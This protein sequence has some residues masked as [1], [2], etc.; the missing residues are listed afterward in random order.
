MMKKLLIAFLFS[1]PLLAGAGTCRVVSKTC[2]DSAE[3]KTVSGMPVFFATVGI[4]DG[5]WE[6]KNEYDCVDTSVAVNYCAGIEQTAGCGTTSSV[7][8]TTNVID[9]SCDIYTKTFR[10][11]N[12]VTGQT[13]VV[14]LNNTYTVV[15]DAADYDACSSYMQNASCTLAGTVCTDGP[16]TKVVA[17]GGSTRLATPAEIS[18]GVSTDGAVVF[19]S[20]WSTQ[21]T[22][23]CIAGNYANYCQP[24][25]GA[26]CTESVTATCKNTA[27]DGSC[28]E[29]ERTYNCNNQLPSNPANVTYLNSSY[30]IVSDTTTTT[31]SDPA[32]SPNCVQA[33]QVCT[34]GPS[35]K[36]VFQ[37]GT[38]RLAT[39]AEI[40]SGVSADGMV[41][42][43]TCWAYDYTY[44]CASTTL[45][46]TCQALQA[47]ANCVEKSASCIDY[48]NDGVNCA[49][50]QHVYS[51]QTGGGG[52][53]T[54]TD[55]GTQKY[56]SDGNCFDTGYPP[57]SD[58]G[59]VVAGK[60]AL[61]EAGYEGIFKGEAASCTDGNWGLSKC[62]KV[63]SG[64]SGSSNYSVTSQMVSSGLMTGLNYAGESIRQI[65]SQYLYDALFDGLDWGTLATSIAGAL[66]SEV[67][68]DAQTALLSSASTSPVVSIGAYGL[69]WAS[70]ATG[71]FMGGNILLAGTATTTTAA[72]VTTTTTGLISSQGVLGGYLYFNPYTFIIAIVIM[73]VMQMMT[74][75]DDNA[76]KLGIK[77]GQGLCHMVGTY[78]SSKSLGSCKS[79]TEGWCCFPSKLARIINEQGRPQIGKGWGQ[80]SGPDCSGFSLTEVQQLKFDQ[81]D[82]S[83]FIGDVMS[84]TSATIS[85]KS[86]TYATTRAQT[87]ASSGNNSSYYTITPTAVGVQ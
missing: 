22:Y 56:C 3:P 70:G 46:S 43:K 50:Y 5:C 14:T 42:T 63:Y 36:V 1:L 69:T 82:L 73:I 54:V 60:E 26:G 39:A 34:D 6:W 8:T 74:C 7:C 64:G 47:D 44:T 25:V 72:G 71:G 40:A 83:E 81:M 18:S 13:N 67:V 15:Q 52:T 20:C 61:L 27:W 51:C 28:L 29:Y 12:P 57:D 4:Q 2:I 31:C 58:I 77:R 53:Q 37:D 76:M 21:N 66:G 45:T 33:G 75:G 65:G 48:L 35:T 41:M 79:T 55:C 23:T 68:S 19:E 86:S 49:A 78:C 38:S 9:G 24:L 11:G 80:A 10:C 59:L 84:K 30:S 16:S 85:A 62:C 32:S 17:P 87:R